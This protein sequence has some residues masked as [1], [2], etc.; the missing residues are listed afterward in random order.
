MS[1]I[2]QRSA[3]E[4]YAQHH[5]LHIFKEFEKKEIAQ[6][7]SP[8]TQMDAYLIYIPVR[9]T[10][11]IF[12]QI[13]LLIKAISTIGVVAKERVLKKDTKERKISAD[14]LP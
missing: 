13:H 2:K 7:S 3:I 5:N 1:L 12:F 6:S 14:N 4:R 8:D 11:P 10:E 9:F